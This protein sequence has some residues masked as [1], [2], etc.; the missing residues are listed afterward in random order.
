MV[1]ILA[2]R[3]PNTLF[4]LECLNSYSRRHGIADLGTAGLE[5]GIDRRMGISCFADA[6]IGYRYGYV[7][8]ICRLS[9]GIENIPVCKVAGAVRISRDRHIAQHG[10]QYERNSDSFSQFTP[11]PFC[12]VA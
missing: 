7:A 12:F 10:C 8:D 3:F 5:I 1:C 9:T 11:S 2:N 6:F 4:Q